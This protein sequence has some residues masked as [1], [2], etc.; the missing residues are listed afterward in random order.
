VS[1]PQFGSTDYCPIVKARYA[2]SISLLDNSTRSFKGCL[3]NSRELAK[4][5]SSRDMALPPAFPSCS[6]RGLHSRAPLMGLLYPNLGHLSSPSDSGAAS[7]DGRTIGVI[8]INEGRQLGDR[9]LSGIAAIA[10][11]PGR[12]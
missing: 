7:R 2:L 6:S 4:D 11:A 8:Q 9:G 12:P 1:L 5:S 3:P 10:A